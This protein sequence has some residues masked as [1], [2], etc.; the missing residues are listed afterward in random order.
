MKVPLLDLKAH[1]DP[2][3]EEILGAVK[4]VLDAQAFILGPK[5]AAFEKRVASY[6]G[7]EHAIGVSSGTDALVVSLMALEVGPGDEVITTPYSFFASV[8][9]IARV[10]A[11]PV[12]VDIDPVTYNIDVTKIEPAITSRTRAILPV[13]LFGQCAEMEPI[14]AMAKRHGLVVVED[15]AQ[16][17]GAQ[18]RDGRVAGSMGSLGCLSFFPSKNLGGLGDGGMVLTNDAGLAEKVRT[19]RV[20]GSKPKYY[21]KMVGGNFRL[22]A[23]HAS[24]LNIKLNY[25]DGWT[26]RRQEHARRY[27]ELF[28]ESCLT[29]EAGVQLPVAQY[30]HVG[31]SRYHIYNQFVIRAPNRDGLRDHLNADS[32]GTAVYYPVPFHLQDCF[33][34]L[35]YKQ[36]D[37]PASE[38]AATETLVL[39]IY[40]ELSQDQ[41]QFVVKSIKRFYTQLITDH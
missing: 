41:Q 8:G 7:V 34:S 22:D 16:A 11:K 28:K 23:L 20:H 15:A 14:L 13:H 39:P 2:I 25:L 21:H 9:C 33:R 12:F 40:P 31:V 1:H 4:E 35:G 24:V 3:R 27:F 18:Y 36:G 10:G 37:F 19:L 26:R 30:E 32:I 5:V 17:V 38:Q 29:K 6:C